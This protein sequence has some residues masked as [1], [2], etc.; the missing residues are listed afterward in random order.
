MEMTDRLLL[1]PSEVAKLLGVGRSKVY[2]LIATG[3]IPSLRLGKCV[4]VQA[5]RLR[6]WIE[7]L[8]TENER[9]TA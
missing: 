2:E 4:R 7:D 3:V 1:R 5:D 9:K 6:K 8:Q